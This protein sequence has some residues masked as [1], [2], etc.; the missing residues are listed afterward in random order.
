VVA[1]VTVKA[2]ATRIERDAH[3]ENISNLLLLTVGGEGI[4]SREKGL[5]KR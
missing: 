1:I 5:K 2:T 3:P 4:R